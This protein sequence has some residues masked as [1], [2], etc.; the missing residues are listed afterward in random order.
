LLAHAPHALAHLVRCL[1]L[2]VLPFAQL[3]AL[4]VRDVDFREGVIRLRGAPRSRS[5]IRPGPGLLAA[6]ADA[7]GDRQGGPAVPAPRGGRWTANR[8]AV[9]F[10][11]ARRRAGLPNEIKLRARTTK[12][13]RAVLSPIL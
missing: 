13:S 7:I 11:H 1:D 5:T 8:A 6:L 9:V 10:D 12:Q 2:G 3:I 4:D